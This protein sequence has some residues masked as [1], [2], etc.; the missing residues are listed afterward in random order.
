[1]A[2][3]LLFAI[4]VFWII[5]STTSPISPATRVG[6]TTLSSDCAGCWF[7]PGSRTIF[8][9]TPG[10][11]IYQFE[12]GREEPFPIR[13]VVKSEIIRIASS[14][15]GD[16]FATCHWDNSIRVWDTS[17][18][19]ETAAMVGHSEMVNALSF[20]HDGTKL[21]SA[22]ADNTV[23]IWNTLNGVELM[24]CS[25]FALAVEFSPAGASFATG[26][27]RVTI[28]SESTGQVIASWPVIAFSLNAMAFSPDGTVLYWGGNHHV[29]RAIHSDIFSV[30]IDQPESVRPFESCDGGCYRLVISPDGTRMI[31]T[32]TSGR[33]VIWDTALGR[34]RNEIYGLHRKVTSLALSSDASLLATASVQGVDASTLD[35][36]DL[37]LSR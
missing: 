8:A 18:W 23:R 37:D 3:L 22:S 30:K 14:P 19:K 29:G 2:I 25:E 1:V 11:R 28:W 7:K 6:T 26:G 16:Q 32:G 20:S 9:L 31:S 24:R 36:W 21:V 35:F 17:T 33:V 13:L 4:G 10:G 5:L 27:Q 15:Q 12:N 34:R